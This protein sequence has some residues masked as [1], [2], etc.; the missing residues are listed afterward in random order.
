MVIKS[1]GMFWIVKI[2]SITLFSV[3]S[4]IVM[5]AQKN[6]ISIWCGPMHTIADRKSDN[7]NGKVSY[8]RPITKSFGISYNHLIKGKFSMEASFFIDEYDAGYDM[9]YQRPN[10]GGLYIGAFKLGLGWRLLCNKFLITG[11]YSVIKRRKW[12]S[13]T[14]IGVG[15]LYFRHNSKFD[16]TAYSIQGEPLDFMTVPAYQREG[17][18]LIPR[19]GFDSKLKIYKKFYFSFQ[20]AFQKGTRVFFKDVTKISVVGEPNKGVTTATTAINGTTLQGLFGLTFCF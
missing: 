2:V 14:F 19:I 7:V 4:N 10:N 1:K 9:S 20:V 11:N 17:I 3:A 15:I 18:S 13:S 8:V 5:N 16:D 6:S 12:Q